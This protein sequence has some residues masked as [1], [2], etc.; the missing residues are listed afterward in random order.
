MQM[1]TPSKQLICVSNPHQTNVSYHTCLFSNKPKLFQHS[2]EMYS[3]AVV[4][5]NS[6]HPSVKHRLY[7][8]SQETFHLH[9]RGTVK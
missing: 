8:V 7:D 9:N 4:A 6:R 2:R 3:E 1:A 5:F